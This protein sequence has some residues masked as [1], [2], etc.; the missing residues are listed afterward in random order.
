MKP[1]L[2]STEVIEPLSVPMLKVKVE[3]RGGTPVEKGELD[4]E[5]VIEVVGE[6]ELVGQVERV[7]D[8]LGV[9]VMEV[10]DVRVED[11]EDVKVIE[12]VGVGVGDTEVVMLNVD[13]AQRV[14]VLVEQLL[15]DIE[16]V[17]E[18]EA[19]RHVD[20]VRE[21]RRVGELERVIVWVPDKVFEDVTEVLGQNDGDVEIDIDGVVKALPLI[22]KLID[23][24]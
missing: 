23:T 7:G 22:I 1:R 12:E 17:G 6:E 8:C 5:I 11:K 2:F 21:P 18:V 15:S 19:E 14:G 20:G 4:T 16:R 9:R 10:E 13:V 3:K 24:T